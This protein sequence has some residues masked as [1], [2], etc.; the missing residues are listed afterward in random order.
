MAGIVK[1]VTSLQN[2]KDRFVLLVIDALEE[3]E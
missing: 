1:E 2:Q 3:K